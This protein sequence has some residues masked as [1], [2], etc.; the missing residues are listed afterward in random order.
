MLT[1]INITAAI[2]GLLKKQ[3]DLGA[4]RLFILFPSGR[5]GVAD[6]RKA[7]DARGAPNEGRL[8]EGGSLI[9]IKRFKA[10]VIAPQWV[11]I[12]KIGGLHPPIFPT[13]A[14]D[15]RGGGRYRRD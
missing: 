13:H 5:A 1:L 10:V 6:V 14:T 11:G 15:R 2:P 3:S 9:C 4:G 8:G 12:L 7:V